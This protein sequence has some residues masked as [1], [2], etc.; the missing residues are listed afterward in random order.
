MITFNNKY[1]GMTINIVEIN[2]DKVEY[3][4]L[5]S[6]KSILE[7]S[8][9]FCVTVDEAMETCKETIDDTLDN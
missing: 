9:G 4:I 8:E 1:R 3:K 7:D 6:D 2:S 5:K